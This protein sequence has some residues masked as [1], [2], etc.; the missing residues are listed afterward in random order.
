MAIYVFVGCCWLPVVWLQIRMRDLAM[1]AARLNVPLPEVYRGYYRWWL[2]W[3]GPPS[4]A[5]WSF[6]I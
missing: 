1:E 6:F 2:H 4:P 5:Y 3:G